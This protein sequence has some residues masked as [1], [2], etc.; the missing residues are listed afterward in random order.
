MSP[1]STF[2][3]PKSLPSSTDS[4]LTLA[5]TT[6]VTEI[7]TSTQYD[8]C[9]P[10]NLLGPRLGTGEYIASLQLSDADNFEDPPAENAVQCCEACIGN[11]KCILSEFY[12]N[13]D[14][15]YNV[16]STQDSTCANP[17]SGYL[18]ANL[19]GRPDE[20][21]YQDLIVSNGNCGIIYRH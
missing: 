1:V 21:F 20:N 8:A 17:N 10:T 11:P 12:P 16:I 5:T 7:V 18:A 4:C 3:D 13:S 19:V 9:Q 2:N 14:E 15:C 6:T